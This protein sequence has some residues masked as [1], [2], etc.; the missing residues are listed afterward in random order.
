MTATQGD[1][2]AALRLYEWNAEVSGAFHVCLGQL[3]VLLRNSLDQ[4]LQRYN[5]KVLSAQGRWYDN[6]AMP[7]QKELWDHLK[8]ARRRATR[9]GT[10]PEVHGKVIAEL[11]MGFWSYLLDAHHQAVLWAPALRH[12]FPHL[13]PRVR[14][15]VYD[16]YEPLRE[17]RNRTAH[18]EPI[19][20]LPLEDRWDDLIRVAGFVDPTTAAWIA[21]ASRVPDL[22]RQRP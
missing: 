18:H 7:F 16:R 20:H 17:L 4:Q 6:R 3:E 1:A 9:K 15:E 2:D 11:M 19:F 21:T 22:L 5:K 12:A 14:T 13:R 8:Q 10:I